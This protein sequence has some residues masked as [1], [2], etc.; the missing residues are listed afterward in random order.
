L[1]EQVF[2]SYSHNDA[3]RPIARFLAAG[4]REAGYTVWQDE[5]SQTAGV[6]L[7]ANIEQAI[8]DSQH[9]IFI[10]SKLWL[11]SKWGRFELD[12]FSR[13]DPV[14]VRRVPV[15]RLPYDQLRLPVGLID[16]KG[17]VWLEDDPH[18]D[19]KFW[20]IYC[21][22]AGKDPGAVETWAARGEE[23]QH[24]KVEPPA[25]APPRLSLQSLRCN[26][27]AQWGRILEVSPENSH[28]LLIVPGCAGQAHEHFSQRIRE[29]LTLTPPRNI[30]SV[31]WTERPVSRDEY[32]SCL[33]DD[34]EVSADGLEREMA[35]RM[36]DSNLVLIHRCLRTHYLDPAFVSY[37]TEWLPQLIAAVKPH[38][39]LKC[40]QPI[41]WPEDA[42][43]LGTFLSLM[44]L[45]PAT[46]EGHREAEQ[47]IARVRAGAAATF[48]AI[49]LQDLSN[50]TDADL[51]EFCQV[52]NLTTPQKAWFLER[53]R[54]RNPKTS[55]EILQRI[56]EYLP[57]ARS[58]R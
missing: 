6:D 51:D 47:L 52:Q 14:K 11:A 41:E 20:E 46:P 15:F 28:D 5:S 30:I 2:I 26:R 58:V 45:K 56:D 54:S 27:G 48:R 34:L 17:V 36:S 32:L 43:V 57:D 18:H 13:R 39:R 44:R 50:I 38:A 3:D 23:I 31:N 22:I 1:A 53:I 8:L 9:A 25:P 35:E 40:V 29:M 16:L 37:Y 33:A 21:A 55:E 42:G 49:R 4:L 7:E 12:R 24:G 19:A 10:V